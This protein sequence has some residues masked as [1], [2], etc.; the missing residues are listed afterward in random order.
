MRVRDDSQRLKD[1]ADISV[2][3]VGQAVVIRSNSE[4]NRLAIERLRGI[5][6]DLIDGQGNLTIEVVL[7]AVATVDVP[8]LDVLVDAERGLS[9]RRGRLSVTT[10]DGH[11]A[12]NPRA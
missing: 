11:W 5:L 10:R 1:G 12:S 4:L 2:R 6:A 8:L 7:R 9:A 3:R